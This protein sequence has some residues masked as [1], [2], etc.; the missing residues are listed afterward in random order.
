ME[1]DSARGSKVERVGAAATDGRDSYRHRDVDTRRPV[2]N[3]A[4][5]VDGDQWKVAR[6]KQ[7]RLGAAL[8]GASDAARGRDVLAF[9]PWLEQDLNAPAPGEFRDLFTAGDDQPAIACRGGLHRE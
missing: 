8:D 2:E 1:R 6:Q 3:L 4:D 9:L 5:S 7:P